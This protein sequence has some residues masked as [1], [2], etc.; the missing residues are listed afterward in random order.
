MDYDLL[1]NQFYNDL[2]DMVSNSQS[3]DQEIKYKFKY[4]MIL[5][6]VFIF[7]NYK[8]LNWNNQHLVMF[9]VV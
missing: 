8:S 3:D 1:I 5:L 9:M 7:I 4:V 2:I 6:M